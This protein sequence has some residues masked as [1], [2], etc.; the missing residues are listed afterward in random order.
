[1]N[2]NDKT[3][4]AALT[5]PNAPF[6]DIV[7][8]V[9]RAHRLLCDAARD[10]LM[11]ELPQIQVAFGL[12]NALNP[13]NVNRDAFPK[14]DAKNEW[15][16]DD[17]GDGARIWL[18]APVEAFFWVY[19]EFGEERV[20]ACLGL[21]FLQLKR[22]RTW[23]ESLAGNLDFAEDT[24]YAGSYVLVRRMDL[25]HIADVQDAIEE[26]LRNFLTDLDRA[27]QASAEA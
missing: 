24:W 11:S 6:L 22:R 4:L 7:R 3:F 13:D 19:T 5:A 15:P 26:M 25:I 10:T 21:E 27:R 18:P 8:A 17:C 20:Q 23:F 14:P 1:M 16:Y 9:Y 2:D 12:E